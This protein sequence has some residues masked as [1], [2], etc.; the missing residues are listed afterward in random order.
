[1]GKEARNRFLENTHVNIGDFLLF[2]RPMSGNGIR[3]VPRRHTQDFDMLFK[4]REQGVQQAILDLREGESFI[5]VGANV[6]YY[7]LRA[8]STA[9]VK[10]SSPKIISIEAHPDN[11]RALCRNIACNGFTNIIALNRAVWNNGGSIALTQRVSEGRVLTDDA[12][13]LLNSSAGAGSELLVQADTLDNITKEHGV[14]NIGVIKMDIEGSEIRALE[15]AGETM[16][17]TRKMVVETH[18]GND[19][20]VQSILQ[21]HGFRTRIVTV[22]DTYQYPFV[23]GE[24]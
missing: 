4:K 2:E 18:D 17:R 15:A 19:G 20:Q 12:R 22:I 8:A 3:A 9:G 1:M 10:E 21:R 24:K 23:I 16:R 7:T 6:G 13:I 11:Y 5:D 14:N